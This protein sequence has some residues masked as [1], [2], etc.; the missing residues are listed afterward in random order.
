MSREERS[1][2][3]SNHQSANFRNPSAEAFPTLN[4][5]ESMSMGGH[6]KSLKTKKMDQESYKE[7]KP[8]TKFES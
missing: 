7:V 4:L 3:E 8:F 1:L 6:R 2:L 5:Q